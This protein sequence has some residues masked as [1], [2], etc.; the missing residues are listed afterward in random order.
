M[1]AVIDTGSISGK[2]T[3]RKLCH[4]D[5]PSTRAASITSPG[6]GLEP[7]QQHDHHERDEDPGVEDHHRELRQPRDWRRTPDPPS[8]ARARAATRGRSGTRAWT[9]RSSTTRPPATASA[10]AG[11]RRGRTGVRGSGR[12]AAAPGRRRWR[13]STRIASAV[14]D[15]VAER[16]PVERVAA[17]SARCCRGRRTAGP[18]GDERFQ[19]E[20]AMAMPRTSGMTVSE[21]TKQRRR[22]DEQDPLALLAADE[23]LADAQARWPT[24]CRRTAWAA[25]R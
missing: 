14:P 25:S 17:A 19:S 12:A 18:R 13:S 9:C 11:T 7:G 5:A 15:H 23:H 22:Q 20:N 3:F 6:Q 16:V 1:M 4:A 2:M 24:G 8:R 10:A 21:T